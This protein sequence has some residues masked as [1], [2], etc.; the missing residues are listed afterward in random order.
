MSKHFYQDY[1]RGN[2]YIIES[3]YLNIFKNQKFQNRKDLKHEDY[4]SVPKKIVSIKDIEY[5]LNNYGFRDKDFN[6]PCDLL[7]SGCSQTWGVALPEEYRFSNI[8]E[9][10]IESLVHNIATPGN[11]V[12]SV[13]RSVFAY[14]KRFGNPKYIYC[15]MPPFERFE[16]VPD[17][18]R[19]NSR[20]ISELKYQE[21]GL[22]SPL[23]VNTY[24]SNYDKVQKAPFASECTLNLETIHFIQ[25][26]SILMLEQYCEAAGI[27]LM[28]STWGTWSGFPETII[29]LKNKGLGYESFLDLPFKKWKYDFENQK[30]LV[31]TEEGCH[32]EL[33]NLSPEF[34]NSAADA[35]KFTGRNFDNV[36]VVSHWG[37]HRNAHIADLV[38][39]KMKEIWDIK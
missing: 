36:Q 27:K 30:D 5:S 8:I 1:S 14:I 18:E 17:L 12:S 37:S 4:F 13:V 3:I 22:L 9:N 26:Q 25:A 34:F 38:L 28:W 21:R 35:D 6:D 7:V 24:T 32:R 33:N 15:M 19:F 10:N 11:S 29:D 2:K 20:D 23:I 16:Y 39:S 31:S